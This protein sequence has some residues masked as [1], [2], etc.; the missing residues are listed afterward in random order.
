M[1]LRGQRVKTSEIR[2]SSRAARSESMRRLVALL[3]A[4]LLL[5]P[6]AAD[7]QE[8]YPLRVDNDYI[9]NLTPNLPCRGL[10]AKAS[11]STQVSLGHPDEAATYDGDYSHVECIDLIAEPGVFTIRDATFTLSTPEGDL[12]GTHSARGS[13]PD[14]HLH[15]ALSGHFSITGG[16]GLFAGATGE[17]I[18]VWDANVLTREVHGSLVGVL[19]L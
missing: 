12:V 7:A 10:L 13:L 2:H 6:T 1:I 9:A 11:G 15:V 8:T 19:K 4:G 18:G 14:P 3:I 5:V 16:T 17:G